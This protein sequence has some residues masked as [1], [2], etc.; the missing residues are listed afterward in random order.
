[1]APKPIT[2]WHLPSWPWRARRNQDTPAAASCS[3]SSSRYGD[4]RKPLANARGSE[5]RLGVRLPGLHFHAAVDHAL[6][7][8]AE[9]HVGMDRFERAGVVQTFPK[10]G[11]DGEFER[12]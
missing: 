12:R 3:N 6:N 7:H 4:R 11:R 9:E 8:S 5:S 10:F 1:M 2:C